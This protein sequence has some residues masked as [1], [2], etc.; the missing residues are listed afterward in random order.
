M[1]ITSS[2]LLLCKVNV[3]DISNIDYFFKI[4]VISRS[5]E[6]LFKCN[7]LSEKISTIKFPNYIYICIRK[8]KH[9]S[10]QDSQK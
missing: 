10:T 1:L 8:E 6:I 9:G 5:T 3:L 2:L 7:F 4:F